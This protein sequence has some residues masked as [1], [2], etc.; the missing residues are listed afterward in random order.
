MSFRNSI[1][2][3]KTLRGGDLDPNLPVWFEF[4]N[5]KVDQYTSC[6]QNASGIRK[7][8]VLRSIS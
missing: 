1:W 7:M 5:L 2:P 3:T 4:E 6:P 8:A